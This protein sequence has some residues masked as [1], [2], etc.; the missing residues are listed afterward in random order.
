MSPASESG[1]LLIV[2][3]AYIT[4]DMTIIIVY[5]NNN[6]KHYMLL[7]VNMLGFTKRWITSGNRIS[8]GTEV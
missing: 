1:Y 7:A 2:I 6:C 4:L 5:Y 3:Q 8:R